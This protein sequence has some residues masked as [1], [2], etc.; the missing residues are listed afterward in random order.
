MASLEA[1]YLASLV[2]D[3]LGDTTDLSL[4]S[5]ALMEV[6]KGSRDPEVLATQ[7]QTAFGEGNVPTW[8]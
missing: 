6:L 1:R 3:N 5:R 4:V 2:V 8:L 7:I